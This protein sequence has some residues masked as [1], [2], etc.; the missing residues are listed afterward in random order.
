MASL[1]I[2]DISKF[3]LGAFPAVLYLRAGSL[4]MLLHHIAPSLQCVANILS[5]YCDE[6]ILSSQSDELIPS[7][8]MSQK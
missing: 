5:S 4:E 1:M 7:L 6:N 8:A 2:Q 3:A